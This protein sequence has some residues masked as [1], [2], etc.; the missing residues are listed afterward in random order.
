MSYTTIP[1]SSNIGKIL[2]ITGPTASGKSGLAEYIALRR[3]GREII[4][5]DSRQIYKGLDIGTAKPKNPPVPYHLIDII[6]PTER[7]SAARFVQDAAE[8]IADILQRGRTP[9]VVGGTGLYIRALTIGIF[10]GEFRDDELRAELRRR[11]DA[12]DDLFAE[13]AK[14]DPAAAEKIDPR[15]FVRIQRALEVYYLSGKP[16][17]YH[18]EHSEYKKVP[19]TFEKVAVSIPRE[20]L[21]RRIRERVHK[22]LKDGWIEETRELLKKLTPPPIA[23]GREPLFPTRAPAPALLS[24]GYPEIIAYIRGE[25]SIEELPEKIIAKTNGYARRQMVWF[26]KEPD[27]RWLTAAEIKERYANNYRE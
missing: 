21:R 18:W 27:L 5:A 2:L 16:I 9:I 8:K 1:S 14:I 20:E 26:R 12:G 3:G 7:Y 15:N 11:Y 25:L 10:D 24:L 23:E 19:Y 6:E 22:M 17:S 13:L 4:S